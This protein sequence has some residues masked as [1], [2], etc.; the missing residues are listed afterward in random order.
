MN[1][2]V[3]VFIHNKANSNTTRPVA[4][5]NNDSK[6]SARPIPFGTSNPS[7]TDSRAVASVGVTMAASAKAIGKAQPIAQ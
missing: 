1:E 5:L 7:V 4:S 6:L 2:N 3:P